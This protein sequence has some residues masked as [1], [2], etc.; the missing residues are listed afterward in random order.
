MNDGDWVE[1]CT[2]LVEHHDGSWE[3][4]TW[5]QEKDDVDHDLASSTLKRSPRPAR[6][7]RTAISGPDPV[8]G[9]TGH[10]AVRTKV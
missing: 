3:I 7:D 10:D 9:S 6:Q 8:P 4:V 5:T 1:S 2:A